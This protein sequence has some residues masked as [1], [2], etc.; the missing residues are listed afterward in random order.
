MILASGYNKTKS[1]NLRGTVPAVQQNTSCFKNQHLKII[2]N[3]YGMYML[4]RL[5]KI[6]V[7]RILALALWQISTAPMDAPPLPIHF[8]IVV[9]VI[10]YAK[11]MLIKILYELLKQAVQ[12]GC[13]Q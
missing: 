13:Y 3:H 10:G 11:T 9:G 6:S 2:K 5:E 8:C 7:G 4:A 12:S 1:K